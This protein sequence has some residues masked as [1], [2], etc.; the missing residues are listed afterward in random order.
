MSAKGVVLRCAYGVGL[1]AVIVLA[2]SVEP[3]LRK[4]VG[5]LDFLEQMTASARGGFAVVAAPLVLLAVRPYWWGKLFVLWPALSWIGFAGAMTVITGWTPLLLVP[6]GC[7]GVMLL[8]AATHQI[9]D[10][11]FSGAPLR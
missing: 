2:L 11:R 6:L 1:I 8:I 10:P 7:G 5:P 9:L 3:L 4:L